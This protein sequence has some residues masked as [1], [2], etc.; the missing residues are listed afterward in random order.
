MLFYLGKIASYLMAP[1]SVGLILLLLAF[2]FYRRR[3]LGRVLLF[4]GIVTLW[5]FSI[6]P[7]SQRLM[8]GLEYAVPGYTV[9][10]APHAD[11]IV[12][13]GGL[14][15][16]PSATRKAPELEESSDRLMQALRLYHAGKA[17]LILVTSGTVAILEGKDVMNEAQAARQVLME[18][19]VP[20]SAIV[21][22]TQSQNTHE[23][24]TETRKI[25]DSRG[26][27]NVLLVT[28]A[29]HMPRS[30]AVFRKEGVNVLPC[31]TDYRTGWGE[32]DRIFQYLPDPLAAEDTA[33]VVKERVGL[34][35]YRL[36]G[37]A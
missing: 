30:V 23:N 26:L 16:S 3:G 8:Y 2:V 27:H 7:V 22:E 33:E 21:V 20:D 17:P 11:A 28:S 12:V 6:R 19:G 34:L 35:I 1:L 9:E 4:L 25:L 31:P 32:P 5:A 15:H 36:H 18:W 14:L 13:L 24:A 10:T 37:W 29:Y